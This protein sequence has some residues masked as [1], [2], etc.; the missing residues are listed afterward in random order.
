MCVLE[1]FCNVALISRK[2]VVSERNYGGSEPGKLK[3]RAFLR[4]NEIHEKPSEPEPRLGVS[5]HL[6]F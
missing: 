5:N 2:R 3:I 6:T 1:S 4:Q